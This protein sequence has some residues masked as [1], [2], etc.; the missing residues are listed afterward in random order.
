[1]FPKLEI[2]A[3]MRD[4]SK[5][6]RKE[7]GSRFRHTATNLSQNL[8]YQYHCSQDQAHAKTHQSMIATEKQRDDR[9]MV[10]FSCKSKLN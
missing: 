6:I 1:M 10:P 3:A 8:T 4:L 9:R 7:G 2:N 5:I